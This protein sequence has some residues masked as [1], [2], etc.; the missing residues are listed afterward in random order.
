MFWVRLEFVLREQFDNY[1][2]EVYNI[3]RKAI[4]VVSVC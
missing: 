3:L 2:E 1:A 4:R